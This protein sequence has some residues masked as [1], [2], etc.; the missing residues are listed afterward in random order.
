MRL[1]RITAE[2]VHP[3]AT[4]RVHDGALAEEDAVSSTTLVIVAH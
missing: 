2:N 3:S 1:I 4:V